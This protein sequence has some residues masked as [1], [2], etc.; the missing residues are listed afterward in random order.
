[1]DKIIKQKKWPIKRILIWTGSPLLVVV[2][3][4][5]AFG[6][7]SSSYR[8]DQNR[9]TISEVI[10]GE[11]QDVIPLQG[12][13]EPLTTIQI[14][15]SEGG[16]VEE[17]FVEDGIEV[18]QGQPL[19]RLSNTNL[20]LDFMNRETQIVEQI[21]NLR[22]TRISLDQNQRQVQEQLV[23]LKYQLSE[24]ERQWK[25][26]SQLF[27]QDA[28]SQSEFDASKANT[29]YL[30]EKIALLRDRLATDEAYRSNQMNRIDASIEMMERNL[31]AIRSNLENLVVKAPISGQLNSFDHEIGQSKNRGENLGRVDVLDG[32]QIS[33]QVDQY[34]LNRVRPD[35]P[36][37]IDISGT[38][39]H[40]KV[41]KVLPTVVNNQFEIHLQFLDTLPPNIRR[42]QNIQVRLE[43]SAK[44]KSLMV[45]RGGFYQ[46]SGGNYAY[47]VNETGEAYKREISLGPQNPDYI[48]VISGLNEGEQV[49]TSSYE[50]FGD[51]EK[52]VLE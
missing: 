45:K 37:T 3:L 40:L 46:S 52:I 23:D 5:M 36:A 34:Y 7:R 11:F 22:S 13:V 27:S 47:V 39:Y 9:I 48:Q 4:I 26:D 20:R 33:A 21:N 6:D 32:Y 31:E 1:M 38:T 25:I 28:I 51:V 8:V 15:A 17:I 41:A 2:L 24:Q 12:S 18:T 30:R 43:L 42:G 19:M 49:I 16:K 50:G 10:Y 35:Q 29:K 44:T 14:T